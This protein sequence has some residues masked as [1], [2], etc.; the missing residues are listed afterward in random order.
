MKA[1]ILK[2]TRVSEE[3][4][5]KTQNIT[6]RRTTTTFMEIYSPAKSPAAERKGCLHPITS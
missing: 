4:D 2:K 6:R 3:N 1:T 5:T